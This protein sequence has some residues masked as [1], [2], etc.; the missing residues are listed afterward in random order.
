MQNTIK[1]LKNL[2]KSEQKMY[3]NSLIAEDLGVEESLSWKKEIDGIESTLKLVKEYQARN[4]SIEEIANA[5]EK[6]Q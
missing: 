4:L 1:V 5:M 3:N 6:V 2:L